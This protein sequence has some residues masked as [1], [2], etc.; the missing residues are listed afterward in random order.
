MQVE[1]YCVVGF[2]LCR[3]KLRAGAKIWKNTHAPYVFARVISALALGLS[4]GLESWCLRSSRAAKSVLCSGLWLLECWSWFAW[5]EGRPEKMSIAG[6]GPLSIPCYDL[7]RLHLYY[8][9][10]SDC[11]VSL[12]LFF[13]T[14]KPMYNT[15]SRLLSVQYYLV[16]DLLYDI[17]LRAT[18]TVVLSIRGV[19]I[20]IDLVSSATD[21]LGDA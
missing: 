12:F 6:L 10:T 15:I 8:A 18:V 16:S 20:P 2:A 5:P 1:R 3:Q 7:I 19:T 11:L 4:L 14:P 17:H 9:D 21:S 13:L